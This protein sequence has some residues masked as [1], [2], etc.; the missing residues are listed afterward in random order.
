MRARR[1]QKCTENIPS[2]IQG[3][4]K[5]GNLECSKLWVTDKTGSDVANVKKCLERNKSLSGGAR[6]RW[7]SSNEFDCFSILASI[8][9][10][11]L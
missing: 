10:I 8:S 5:V 6:L 7:I 11:G 9:M 4:I 3:C 1:C 2:H